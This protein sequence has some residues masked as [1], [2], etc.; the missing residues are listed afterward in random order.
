MGRIL[1]TGSTGYIGR[2]VVDK[3]LALGE[4]VFGFS[5][6]L[7]DNIMDHYA[8]QKAMEGCDR[9][10]HLAALVSFNPKDAVRVTQTNI[11]GTRNVLS[12]ALHHHIKKVVIASSA[13]TVGVSDTP[14]YL[15]NE[16]CTW[17]KIL[18]AYTLSKMATEDLARFFQT[19]IVMPS[20]ANIH[21]FIKKAME[22]KILVVPP[23]GTNVISVEDVAEGIVMAMDKGELNQRYILSNVNI[24]Y[25]DLFHRI[26]G[27]S[28]KPI[29]VLP[30]WTKKYCKYIA[31]FSKDRYVSPFTV[32]SSYSYKYY[33]NSKAKNFLGWEPKVN[34]DAMIAKEKENY[35]AWKRAELQK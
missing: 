27:E 16:D 33:A 22:D 19:V 23:G 30:K 17:P 6:S 18:D 28:R 24:S 1:V 20:T 10:I 15:L 14:G 9:V 11:L 5:T 34:L 3:L 32:D 31:R 8:L 29:I 25:A 12:A 2:A 26:L 13:I 4:S 7:G 21:L 35:Q